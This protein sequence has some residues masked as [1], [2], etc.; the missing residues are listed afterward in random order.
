MM[1]ESGTGTSGH[2]RERQLC[3]AINLVAVFYLL[4]LAISLGGATARF[5]QMYE[6]LGAELSTPLEFL[7]RHGR[8]FYPSVFGGL[9]VVVVAK[10]WVIRDKRASSMVT[11]LIALVAQALGHVLTTAYYQPVFEMM[12]KLSG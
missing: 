2:T 9:A 7:I 6:A 12:R 3:L 5:A 10:E 11:L 8:W 1:N 4:W